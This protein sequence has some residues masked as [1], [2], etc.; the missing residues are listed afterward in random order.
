MIKALAATLV[1]AIA[2]CLTAAVHAATGEAGKPSHQNSRIHQSKTHPLLI[3]C[4]SR[5]MHTTAH[6]SRMKAERWCTE[7]H[8][9]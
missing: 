1:V 9:Y 5:Q 8:Q 7:H 3:W 6:I 2:L 4:I